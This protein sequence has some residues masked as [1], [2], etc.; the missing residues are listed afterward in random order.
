[1]YTDI[2]GVKMAENK[3]LTKPLRNKT[4]HMVPDRSVQ[5]K[6]FQV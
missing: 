5:T 6:T 4:G 1:M 3:F 2:T